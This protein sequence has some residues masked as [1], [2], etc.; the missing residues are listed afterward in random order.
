MPVQVETFQAPRVWGAASEAS[1]GLFYRCMSKMDFF[2]CQIRWFVSISV[3]G[4]SLTG[5]CPFFVS[6]EISGC[7]MREGSGLMAADYLWGFC[8]GEFE[9]PVQVE[10][11]QAPR[12]WGAASE[13]SR[14]LF[15]RCMSKMDFFFCQIRWFVSISVFGI[16]LTGACPFFVSFEISGC[17]MREGSGLMAADYLWGFCTGEFEMPVQVETFQAPR[18]WGAASEASRGLFYRCMSKM[19]FFFCQIRWFVSISVFGISLTGAC[20]FF[21]SF[22]ISGCGMREGSGLMAADYLWGFCTGEFE[23][24]VQVETFQAPRVWGAA[25]E[26]SRGLFYRCKSKMR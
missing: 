9:M 20:P 21:V 10:T 24:P 12:V 4:I 15:Y 13:A 11:F 19:D 22:E 8:T 7:G 25:S 5:A 14:G 1:R 6:F 2:F 26:A 16:S 18:V 3:F 23:M 17:G